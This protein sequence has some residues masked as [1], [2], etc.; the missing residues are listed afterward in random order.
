MEKCARRRV[1]IISFIA[2]AALL[3]GWSAQGSPA[4]LL[5]WHFDQGIANRWG[6]EYNGYSREPSS[7]RTYLDAGVH[8]P[9]A[10][11][12]L[13]ITAHRESEGFCGVWLE[14]H[15]SSRP[16]RGYL[17]AS[18][19]RFISFW[20][21]GRVAGGSLDVTM[22]DAAAQQHPDQKSTAPI[23]VFV[24][25]EAQNEW[26]E[27]VIPLDKFSGSNLR[28]LSRLILNLTAAGD[29]RFFIDDVAFKADESV[30]VPP[31]KSSV[32]I[33]NEVT[34]L[35]VI[36][37]WVWNVQQLL[38]EGG[39]SE[40]LFQFCAKT[41]VNR[42][43]LALELKT[44]STPSS[45]R[46]LIQQPDEYRKFLE[47]AHERGLQVEAL[48]GT[49]QWA[50]NENHP[51]AM[52]AVDAVLDFNHSAPQEARFDGLH[53]DV[54]PYTLASYVD[55]KHAAGLLQ[56]FLRMVSL[57][58]RR[59]HAQPGMRFTC[60]VPAYFYPPPGPGMQQFVVEFNGRRATVGEHLTDL[61]DT[62][63][64]MDYHNEADGA[65]G[66]IA[67]ALPALSYAASRGKTILVGLETSAEP[68]STVY[69]ICGLPR[70]EFRK[71]LDVSGLGAQ[72][73]VDGYRL[74]SFTDGVNIHVGLVAPAVLVGPT[75]EAFEQ[76]LVRLAREF[77]AASDPDHFHASD[78]MEEAR[79]ALAHDPEWEGFETF[80]LID[81]ETT[82]PIEC[83]RTVS[84][85][86]ARSTFHGLGLVV[87]EEETRSLREWLS[88]YASFGGFA[89][90][91]Y[92]SYRELVEGK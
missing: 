1:V 29:S 24:P 85:M 3:P 31:P 32:P 44:A 72:L 54:E 76:A 2:A 73:S 47:G 65:G 43:F 26:L 86:V 66:S 6:G 51:D 56:D 48:A 36:A 67:A 59:I 69:F 10:A 42:I 74:V 9:G 87:F 4:A 33:R 52:A 83:F 80:E 81:P 30:A 58:A 49:P 79:A 46:F 25:S 15:P 82:R 14:F 12:S 91:H 71:R 53:F 21:K 50:A 70:D 17:D 92:E 89:I 7:V 22:E 57:C 84:R 77:G 16:P 19:Y 20:I 11:H 34:R 18:P 8:K 45:P 27:V 40:R 23:T 88:P 64:L 61:L 55:V 13:R 41:G 68:D 62:V 37:M 90:H 39:G 38:G 28:Q 78:I 35:P 60:D 5:V 75:R 63:T